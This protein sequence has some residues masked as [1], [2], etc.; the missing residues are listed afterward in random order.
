MPRKDKDSIRKK[1]SILKSHP[2]SLSP[3][4]DDG[5]R[6]S[7]SK[8][9]GIQGKQRFRIR[10]IFNI[11]SIDRP[12]NNDVLCSQS[13]IARC[14]FGNIMF[15]R[16]ADANLYMFRNCTAAHKYLLAQS[17]VDALDTRFLKKERDGGW[18]DIGHK[19]AIQYT[20]TMLEKFL[21]EKESEMI[22]R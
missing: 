15:Y 22:R 10:V 11:S 19:A 18:Y 17:I 16:L 5:I 1:D 20:L 8:I 4:K 21:A 2:F 14:H 12:T 9:N 6:V 13:R 3:T 7:A